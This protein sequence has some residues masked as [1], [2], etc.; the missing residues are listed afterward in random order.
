V[1]VF[2]PLPERRSEKAICSFD[3]CEPALVIVISIYSCDSGLR[4]SDL[5]S[6]A[7]KQ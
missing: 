2:C 6:V 1:D 5:N 7:A 4:T 3:V